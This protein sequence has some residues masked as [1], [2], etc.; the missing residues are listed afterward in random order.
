M[1]ADY[2]YVSGYHVG[3]GAI[4]LL[5]IVPYKAGAPLRQIWLHTVK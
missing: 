3:T 5:I 4:V 1:Y 2:T